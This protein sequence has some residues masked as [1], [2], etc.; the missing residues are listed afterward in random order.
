MSAHVYVCMCILKLNLRQ[1]PK[2]AW[3]FHVVAG[4]LWFGRAAK[5]GGGTDGSAHLGEMSHWKL[6]LRRLVERRRDAGKQSRGEH[7]G[8]C[9]PSLASTGV[10]TK[11]MA[12]QM[13]S[14]LWILWVV[15]HVGDKYD[16]SAM[17]TP[18]E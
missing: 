15:D 10:A 5:W 7:T 11:L 16:S 3:H 9:T 6:W 18:D 2:M 4:V 8:E 17:L 12:T 14:Y 1:G 13:E